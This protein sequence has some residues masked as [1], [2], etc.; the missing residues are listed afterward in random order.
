[1]LV[2]HIRRVA[3]G[4]P[5]RWPGSAGKGHMSPARLPP[6]GTRPRR[7]V[8]SIILRALLTP[9]RADRIGVRDTEDVCSIWGSRVASRHVHKRQP[10]QRLLYITL[11]DTAHIRDDDAQCQ[12]GPE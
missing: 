11:V 12:Y 3:A 6:G 4:A 9:S 1:V 10:A 7:A 2:W 8:S 5:K